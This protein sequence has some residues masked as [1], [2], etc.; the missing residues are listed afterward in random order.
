MGA[1]CFSV[2]VA[3]KYFLLIQQQ[4]KNVI[5][6]E[7]GAMLILAVYLNS[8][9]SYPAWLYWVLFLAPDIG[10]VGYLINTRTGAALYNL[11]HHKGVAIAFYLAGFYLRNE[12][13]MFTGLLLFG[14][15]S[16]DRMLGY[17]LKHADSFKHTHLGWLDERKTA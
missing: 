17:G 9:L 4:M 7:E 1:D 13:L 3:K 5:R 10:M 16:F 11:F 6:L 12:P 14:H 8:S 15:S 2:V